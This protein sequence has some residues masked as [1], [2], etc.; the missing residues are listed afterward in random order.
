MEAERPTREVFVAF[1]RDVEPRLRLAVV[2]AHGP[3]PG[4]DAVQEALIWGWEHWG[5]VTQLANPAGYLYRVAMRK[6]QRARVRRPVVA[7]A[8]SGDGTPWVEP[9]LSPALKAMSA[10]QRQTV[11][12]VAAYGYTQ[13]E[14]ADLLGVRRTTVQKHLDRGLAR[15][16]A[17]LRVT[18]DV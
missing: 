11:V 15:L 14:A 17:A 16:R 7:F 6:A 10:M 3:D 2:A 13:Q 12:L 9:A 5:R 1:V 8:T 18:D 4:L